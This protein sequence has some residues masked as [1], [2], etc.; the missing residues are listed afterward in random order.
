ME[1]FNIHDGYIYPLSGAQAMQ[2]LEY[3]LQQ[4]ENICTT[5]QTLGYTITE[6]A[7]HFI[8]IEGV[9]DSVDRPYIVCFLYPIGSGLG[10]YKNSSPISIVK[11]QRENAI[12]YWP[13]GIDQNQVINIIQQHM[14]PFSHIIKG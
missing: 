9:T 3:R 4:F 6:R 1:E 11:L 8:I 13:H 2:K 14:T 5:I 10:L 7:K 12:A